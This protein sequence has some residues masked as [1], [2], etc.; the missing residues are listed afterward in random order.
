MWGFSE[1]ENKGVLLNGIG[2]GKRV[3][4]VKELF[5]GGWGYSFFLPFLPFS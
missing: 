3:S 2:R 5:L 1:L 4:F